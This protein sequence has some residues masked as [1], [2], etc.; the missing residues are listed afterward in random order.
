[1]VLMSWRGIH[2]QLAR[3]KNVNVDEMVDRDLSQRLPETLG[4][5]STNR[6]EAV[7][8]V[9]YRCGLRSAGGT[10]PTG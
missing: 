4:A 10:P 8:G 1:M 6:G 7:G 5:D 9:D 3:G 2:V